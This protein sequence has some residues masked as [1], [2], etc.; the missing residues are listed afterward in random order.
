MAEL[1]NYQVD[2][3]N[4]EQSFD[5]LPAGEYIAVI[6]ASDWKSTKTGSGR[7]LNLQ[8]QIIDG[9]FKGRKLFN[10][11]NLENPNQQATQIA[12]QSLNSIGV[13]CNVMQLQDSTQLHN[14]PM[15]IKVNFKEDHVYGPKNEIKGHK[16]LDVQ[17][18]AAPVQQ[19]Q[20]PPVQQQP[21]SQPQQQQVAPAQD[22]GVPAA[23]PWEV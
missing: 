20:A 15:K 11:L 7:Y 22:D 2:P 16:P 8:Y 12:R 18:Q 6:E 10:I 13:A 5:P 17:Q 19:Q 3:N 23:R 1:G 21:Q 14:I 4:T 9:P